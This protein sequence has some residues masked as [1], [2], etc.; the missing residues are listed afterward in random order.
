MSDIIMTADG[1]VLNVKVLGTELNCVKFDTHVKEKQFTVFDTVNIIGN[2]QK[3]FCLHIENH[4]LLL[5]TNLV[6]K[7]IQCGLIVSDLDIP[8]IQ[9]INCDIEKFIG[10]SDNLSIT[11]DGDDKSTIRQLY[12]PY[13]SI[14]IHERINFNYDIIATENISSKC[15]N[16]M[17]LAEDSPYFFNDVGNNINH[18]DDIPKVFINE[19]IKEL[20]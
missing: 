12:F 14:Y 11:I 7:N 3:M 1:N 10:K 6:F 18:I 2:D 13:T 8:Y 4:E 19:I 9:F 16:F 20:I 15:D 5:G 17:S